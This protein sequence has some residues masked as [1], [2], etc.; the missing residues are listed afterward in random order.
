VIKV[1]GKIATFTGK[2]AKHLKEAAADL[3]LSMQ[4]VFTGMLWEHLMRCA[5]EGFFK[6]DKTKK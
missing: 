2:D 1:K 6:Q 4:D 3:G 5:R